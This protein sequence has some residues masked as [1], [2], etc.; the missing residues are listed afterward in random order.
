MFSDFS[1]IVFPDC[2]I[3]HLSGWFTRDPHILHRVGHI[4]LQLSVVEPRRTR[5]L[6]FADDLFQLSDL[7]RQKILHI[8]SKA[9]ENLS[10]CELHGFVCY[11]SIN[12]LFVMFTHRGVVL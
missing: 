2:F 7:P 6:V 4:L 5:C 10:G 11:G 3:V 1:F 8:V 9:V 12:Y